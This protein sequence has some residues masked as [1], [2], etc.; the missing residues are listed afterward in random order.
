MCTIAVAFGVVPGVPLFVAANRDEFY[1]RPSLPPSLLST[2]PRFIGGTDGE[3]GGTWMGATEGGFFVGLTNQRSMTAAVV[4]RVSR[5]HVVRAALE[6]GSVAGV[7]GLL[8][9]L[10]GARYQPFNLVYG[11]AHE[12]RVAYVRDEPASVEIVT[13]GPGVHV[14]AND[15]MGSPRFPKALRARRLLEGAIGR[16]LDGLIEASAAMLGDHELPGPEL[17]RAAVEGASLPASV[18]G[19][20]QALCVHTDGYGTR[21]S[22]IAAVGEGRVL[23]YLFAEGPSCTAVHK[24]HAALLYP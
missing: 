11:D 12:L 16:P 15:V 20:L 5:G 19:A 1:A 14:L 9:G 3:Q 4:G 23:R 17:L 24:D 7:D 6:A 2:A 8:R 22:T 10:D 21:S 18:A 13:L